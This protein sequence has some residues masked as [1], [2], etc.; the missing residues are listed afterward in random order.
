[1]LTSIGKITKKESLISI[2]F[3]QKCD[4]LILESS[5]PFPGYHGIT[6]P[7]DKPLA[8]YLVLKSNHTDEEIIRAIQKIK[9]GKTFVHFDGAPGTIDMNRK[10]VTVIRI[11]DAGYKDIPAL[12]GKFANHGF[13]FAKYKETPAFDTL[14]KI[15]KY[16]KIKE[17]DDGIFVDLTE[18]CFHYIKIP[19]LP[20][21]ETFEDITKKIKYNI[22]DNNFDAALCSMYNQEGLIDFIRIFDENSGKN[23]MSYIK[24][25]YLDQINKI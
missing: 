16:F 19:V 10:K 8:L 15:T 3:E 24:N 20:D 7:A 1:M 14:I 21:W 6:L 12:L 13:V 4:A 18:E 5:Q 25:K 22:E 9:N 17:I 2:D 23:K 11:K